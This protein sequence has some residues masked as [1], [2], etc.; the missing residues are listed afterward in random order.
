MAFLNLDAGERDDESEPLWGLCRMLNCACGGHAGDAP[1]MARVAAFCARSGVALSAHPSYPDVA[2]FGRTS[3]AM[4][5]ASLYTAVQ[6]QCRALADAAHTHGIA[7]VAMKP[8]GA[9]Y[10]DAAVRP[11][12]AAA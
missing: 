9:L 12:V 5:P 2:G 7:I 10:H 11:D 3:V 1:S 6:M 4:P 8:H